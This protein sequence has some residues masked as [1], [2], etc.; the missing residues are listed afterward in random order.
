MAVLNAFCHA[1]TDMLVRAGITEEV[2]LGAAT[3]VAQD[4]N[5]QEQ[6]SDASSLTALHLSPLSTVSNCNVRI[7]ETHG[8]Y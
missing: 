3:P 1:L 6:R 7:F 5:N 8:S 4:A 2:S